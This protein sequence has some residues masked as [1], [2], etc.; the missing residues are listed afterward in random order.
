VLAGRGTWSASIGART[1]RG[2]R[3]YSEV[4]PGAALALVGSHGFVE[5]AVHRGDAR[6]ALGAGVGDPVQ[7]R[8]E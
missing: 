8:W 2:H 5:I 3:T 1:L 7:V 6:S 4:P